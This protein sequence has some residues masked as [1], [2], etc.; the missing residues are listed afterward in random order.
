MNK[1]KV[2]LNYLMLLLVSILLNVFLFYM[3]IRNPNSSFFDE[4]NNLIIGIGSGILTY[5]ITLYLTHKF[6]Y[7]TNDAL[8]NDLKVL[9]NSIEEIEDR[10]KPL[11]KYFMD[12]DNTLNILQVE[13]KAM[14]SYDRIK[15]LK[16]GFYKKLYTDAKEVKVLG[17]SLKKF[18]EALFTTNHTIINQLLHGRIKVQL[19]LL[20]P[21]SDF[22]KFLDSQEGDNH[23]RHP[24]SDK[25]HEVISIIKDFY[26]LNTDCKTKHDNKIEVRL[27]DETV[28]LTFGYVNKHLN[29]ENIMHLG[30]L[31]GHKEGGPLY[32]IPNNVED[33][34]YKESMDYFDTLFS[35]SE[36]NILFSWDNKGKHFTELNQLGKKI[37]NANSI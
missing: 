11:P 23:D 7:S 16:T 19:L 30:L 9:S 35:K 5:I 14:V 34:L 33:E 31:F 6:L 18:I 1:N 28:T 12:I 26:N 17:I 37:E 8:C 3:I 2:P 21:N 15:L 20:N 32:R 10:T 22:V 36:L 24:V 25:L 4:Y 29:S 13:E 27:I